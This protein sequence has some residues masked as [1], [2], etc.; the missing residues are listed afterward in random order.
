MT[1]CCERRTKINFIF[2]RPYRTLL[3]AEKISPIGSTWKNGR[4][5]S[6]FHFVRK[7]QHFDS[8]EARK[9]A[10]STKI[11][12]LKCTKLQREHKSKSELAGLPMA[13]LLS[14]A[15]T[16]VW[17]CQAIEILMIFGVLIGV[18][19]WFQRVRGPQVI[20]RPLCPGRVRSC[21]A[22]IFRCFDISLFL[23]RSFVAF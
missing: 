2:V 6:G 4:N 7:I 21:P 8:P 17:S 23:Y 11:R 18:E 15:W 10:T 1:Y 20:R 12:K 9:C 13:H 19:A 3:C 22:L 5:T 14:H 16:R